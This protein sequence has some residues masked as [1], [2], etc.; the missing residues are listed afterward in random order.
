MAIE[1]RYV[2]LKQ[3]QIY[4]KYGG[5][6]VRI[7]MVGTNDRIEYTTYVDPRNHNHKHWV[8]ILAHPE[9]GFV[10]RGIKTKVKDGKVL[11]NADSQPLIDW[12]DLDPDYLFSELMQ[13]WAEQ[14][15]R[16]RPNQFRRLFE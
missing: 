14:D 1:Q 5:Q 2:V 15:E 10:L 8:H 9:R 3:E 7:I 12:E 4:S 16:R 11:V 6:I 13:V